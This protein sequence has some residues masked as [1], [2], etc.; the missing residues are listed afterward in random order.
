MAKSKL[1]RILMTVLLVAL[2]LG[3]TSCGKL[4]KSPKIGSAQIT[5]VKMNGL[6]AADAVLVVEVQNPNIFAL[7]VK[8]ISGTIYVGELK[9]ASFTAD[10][11][12]VTKKSNGTYSIPVSGMVC[13]GI[14]GL[15]VLTLLSR[16]SIDDIL[17]DVSAFAK[18]GPVKKTYYREK[19]KVRDLIEG[20]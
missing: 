18:A 12:H 10:P 15:Q 8:D 2:S 7:D 9:L 20:K 17:V 11:V 19:A 3:L 6:K 4:V 13:E 14:S 16:L 5:N 1:S